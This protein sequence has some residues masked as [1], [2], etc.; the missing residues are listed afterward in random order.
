MSSQPESA[1][2]NREAAGLAAFGNASDAAL[3]AKIL[4]DQLTQ[5]LEEDGLNRSRIAAAVGVSPASITLFLNGKY[6]SDD[7]RLR[8]KITAW[9][10]TRELKASLPTPDFVQ[11][12]ISKRISWTCS[13]AMSNGV[14]GLVIGPSGIGKDMGIYEYKRQ[15][16]GNRVVIVECDGVSSGRYGILRETATALSIPH[17]AERN[18]SSIMQD[19]RD[20]IIANLAASRGAGGPGI[21]LIYNEVHLVDYHAVEMIRRIL[22]KSGTG[23]VLVGTARLATQISGKG[24]LMYEQLRRRCRSAATF[25]QIDEVPIE[26]VKAVAESVAGQ[27]L[28][29]TV[30]GLLYSECNSNEPGHM[31]KLGRVA[32]LVHQAMELTASAGGLTVADVDNA[33]TI[34]AA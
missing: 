22:D 18:H 10:R 16:G 8:Q 34:L 31:G 13:R 20:G 9:L 5:I 3:P 21:L 15:V 33:V 29:K 23:G 6:R 2:L 12:S 30:L 11:T 14:I 28:S 19:I 17:A 27:R 24:Q 26:D 7:E 1:D 4:R 25:K 32:A